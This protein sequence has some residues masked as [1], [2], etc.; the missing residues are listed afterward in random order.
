LYYA[1]YLLPHVKDSSFRGLRNSISEFLFA[2]C[3]PLQKQKNALA[4]ELNLRPR[5]VEVWFQNRRAR[6]VFWSIFT[7]YMHAV[8]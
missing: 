2:A 4:K 3:L 7:P 5:Q 8:M 1:L 6:C